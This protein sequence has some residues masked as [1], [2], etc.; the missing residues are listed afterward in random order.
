MYISTHDLMSSF[1]SRPVE[2]FTVGGK[3]F[4]SLAIHA[5]NAPD[6]VIVRA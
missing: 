2:I 6:R 3:T 4:V 1:A 5:G